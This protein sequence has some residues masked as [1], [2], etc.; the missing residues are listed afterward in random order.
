[1]LGRLPPLSA[2]RR[3]QMRQPFVGHVLSNLGDWLNLLAVLNLLLNVWDQGPPVW[4]TV[5]T[6]MEL[7]AAQP[8]LWV[9]P[10]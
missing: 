10:C 1:M 8:M 7:P 6:A 4:G 3:A 9:P 2:L 5:L